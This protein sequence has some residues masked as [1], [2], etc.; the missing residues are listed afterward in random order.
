MTDLRASHAD[1]HQVVEILRVAAGD[2]RLTAGELDER[3]ESA[4]AARTYR[5]LAELTADLPAV[6]CAIAARPEEFLRIDCLGGDIQRSGSW[7]VPPAMDI[8]VV[9]GSVKLDFTQAVISEPALRITAMVRGG[10]LFLIT[11]P[12]IEV[13][14]GQVRLV[15]GNVMIRPAARRRQRAL[16]RIGISGENVAGWLV[17]HAH[18][19]PF[20]L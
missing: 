17:A 2:G 16:L 19:H 3:L 15:A 14:A 13:E 1:R 11:R 12:G 5:E 7:V 18:R 4:L 9:G 8:S 6:R 20:F 10:L